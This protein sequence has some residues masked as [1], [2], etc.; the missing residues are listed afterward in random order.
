MPRQAMF[1]CADC[2]TRFQ[3]RADR[4]SRSTDGVVRCTPC[5]RTRTVPQVDNRGPRNGRYKHGRRVGANITKRAVRAAVAERDGDWCL[6]SGQPGPGLH[7]H[8]VRYGSEGGAYEVDNCVQLSGEAHALVH[9]SKRTWQP[10][11][12][13][14]LAGDPRALAKLRRLAARQEAA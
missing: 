12:V 6:I 11:L 4:P 8:R 9:S 7:L 3:R 5:S 10:I 1:T 14:Y 13:A 2:S